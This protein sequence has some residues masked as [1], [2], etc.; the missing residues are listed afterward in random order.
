MDRKTEV[1]A[2]L[3]FGFVMGVVCTLWTLMVLQ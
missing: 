1:R 3:I 2:A